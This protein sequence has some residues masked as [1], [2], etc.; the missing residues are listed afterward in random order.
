MRHAVI[1]FFF[2]VPVLSPAYG[3]MMPAYGGQTSPA[4][5]Y[6]AGA[7]TVRSDSLRK[8]SLSTAIYDKSKIKIIKRNINSRRYILL[9]IGMMIFLVLILTTVQTWNPG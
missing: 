2:F 7:D 9:A 3:Q 8:D 1:I 5:L 6:R 4:P